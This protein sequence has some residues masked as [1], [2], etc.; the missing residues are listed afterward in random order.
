MI[1]TRIPKSKTARQYRFP[2]VLEVKRAD[3]WNG[4]V[5]WAFVRR[6]YCN[7][8]PRTARLVIDGQQETEVINYEVLTPWHPDGFPAQEARL[9]EQ[10]RKFYVE[11]SVDMGEDHRE[12]QLICT[13]KDGE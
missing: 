6:M 12:H 3:D 5:K 4:K 1:S 9:V 13:L 8:T 11:S 2:V 7:I 10:D